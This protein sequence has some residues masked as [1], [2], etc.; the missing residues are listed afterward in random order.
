[1][2]KNKL[3]DAVAKWGNDNIEKQEP[4]QEIIIPPETREEILHKLRKKL[5]K[6]DY[7][8]MS[9]LLN[10]SSVSNFVAKR[11]GSKWFIKWA[12]FC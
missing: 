6:I 1:M 3:A 12:I 5:Q 8:K 7:Y 2:G 4:V 10:D 9:K 11:G